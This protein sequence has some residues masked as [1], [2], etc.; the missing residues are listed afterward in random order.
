M[1]TRSQS[2]QAILTLILAGTVFTACPDVTGDPAPD[3]VEDL[4]EVDTPDDTEVPADT[5][6][7]D[8][9]T[10]D[11]DG[12]VCGDDGCGGTCGECEDGWDCNAGICEEPPCVPDCEGAACGDPDGCEDGGQC[13]GTCEEGFGCVDLGDDTY[14][15]Q[16]VCVPDCD[17]AACGDA[18]GCE[19]L[20]QG[21]CPAGQECNEAFECVAEECSFDC[22]EHLDCDGVF[23]DEELGACLEPKCVYDE[24]C[25]EWQC[26]AVPV[27]DELCCDTAD[28]CP[29]PNAC[30][31]VACLQDHCAYTKIEDCCLVAPSVL[32]ALDFDD[33]EA[34]QM[35]PTV[36][37]VIEDADTGDM[38]TWTAQEDPCGDGMALYLGDPACE[39]YFNGELWDCAPQNGLDCANDEE[40]PPG[41]TCDTSGAINKCTGGASGAISFEAVVPEVLLPVDAYA[42]MFYTVRTALEPTD[43]LAFDTLTVF[44]EHT[45]DPDLPPVEVQLHVAPQSTGEGCVTFAADLTTFA[46]ISGA[47]GEEVSDAVVNLIWRFDTFDGENNHHKG[48]WLD[49]V[50]VETYCENCASAAACND[51]NVCTSNSCVDVVFGGEVDEGLCY[52]PTIFENCVPC[53]AAGDCAAD[54]PEGYLWECGEAEGFCLYTPDPDLCVLPEVPLLLDAGLEEGELPEEWEIEATDPINSDVTWQ[55]TNATASDGSYALYFGNGEDYD[56]GQALCAAQVTTP[57]IDLTEVAD[58]ND[59]RLSFSLNMSTEWDVVEP[60]NYPVDNA[61]TVQIDVL[62]V[63]VLVDDVVTEVWNSDVLTGTTF[64][65]WEDAWASLSAYKGETIRLR[66]RFYTGTAAPANNDN[67]GVFID[68]IRVE[69]VCGAVCGSAMDCIAG[70]DCTAPMCDF[71]VCSYPVDPECCTDEINPDCDDS[72]PCTNDAC[73]GGTCAH[74]FTGDPQCCSPTPS[75]FADSFLSAQNA[76]WDVPE[77]IPSCGTFPNECEEEEG[78]NCATCPTDCGACPVAWSVTADQS[79]TAPFSLYFGNPLTGTYENGQEKAQGWIAGPDVTMP[80]Y[81]IPAVSFHLFLDTEHSPIF[82]FFEQPVAFDILRLH[83]QTKDGDT[84]DEMVEIWNSMAWDTKGSTYSPGAGQVIWKQVY[85]A[86]EGMGL[87]GETVRFVFEYDSLD[88]SNNDFQGAYVDDF[89]VF[90]LCDPGFECLSAYDCAETSPGTPDC[91][92]ELCDGADGP[93]GVS[94]TCYAEANTALQGCCIQEAVG[95]MASDWDGPCGMEDWVA[96]PTPDQ[97]PVAWQSWDDE[98]HTQGGSCSLYFG[99]PDTGTYDNP[100]QTPQGIVTSPTWAIPA[101]L[102]DVVEVSFWLWMDLEDTWSLTDILS[103]HMGPKFFP[104]L[105]PADDITLWSKPCDLSLGLCDVPGFEAHCASYCEQWGTTNWPWGEWK[106]VT[107]SIPTSEFDGYSHLEFWFEFNAQ[108]DVNNE[109]VGIFVDDFEILTTCQ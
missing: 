66:F 67:P 32:L 4:V 16:V 105:P 41:S 12:L 97:A 38:V 82:L 59:L 40:C 5:V 69:V 44:V 53:A 71:G 48:L 109:G 100:G 11:C 28:D 37:M 89:K 43:D 18:D 2:L 70:G 103:L 23:A 63:E 33:L 108:D 20:C 102:D 13:D 61:H 52:N 83:V 47:P 29:P 93:G 25:A 86:L 17:G 21:T 107:V 51:D 95:E 19:G 65:L 60:G 15:C 64:G 26:M 74:T 58:I 73:Q 75:V 84:Y 96:S 56:C 87:A 9:C 31:T 85:V 98:N 104:T 72:N 24:D 10:P 1:V 3:A 8:V 81:G 68:Q 45:P 54:A 36:A 62:Y 46:P 7:T 77:S 101:G 50:R 99:D 35:P 91:S 88:E 30:S 92:I 79:F 42:S 94:G 106:H 76:A 34:G 90:T 55:V 6:D 49:D 22:S 57:E 14:E 80:P 27:E 39:T 78:E